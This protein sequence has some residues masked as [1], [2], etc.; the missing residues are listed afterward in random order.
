MKFS[1][2]VAFVFLVS[3]GP[4]TTIGS[5]VETP[6]EFPK[7]IIAVPVS[8]KTATQFTHS[9]V[10]VNLVTGDVTTVATLQGRVFLAEA[11]LAV[12]NGLPTAFMLKKAADALADA[13]VEIGDELSQAIDDADINTNGSTTIIF[14]GGS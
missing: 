13:G 2:L 8:I 7:E 14:A 9:V 12:L 6:P 1:V 5:P 4:H 3:C 11:G 10:F